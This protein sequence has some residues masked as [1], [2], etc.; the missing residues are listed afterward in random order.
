M[1]ELALFAGAGGGI[2]GG[3]LLGWRTVCAVELDAYCRRVLLARQR[4][5]FLPRFPIWDNVETFDGKPW[6]GKVDVV[7]GGFP[8]QDLSRA[9][10]HDSGGKFVADGLDGKRSGLWRK[11]ADIICDVQ[12]SYA[13]VENVTALLD[14][15]IG[16]VL[17]DLAALGY[18]AR[19]GVLSA[20]ATGAPHH[21][22]RVF[23]VA[24]SKRIGRKEEVFFPVKLVSGS[25]PQTP[26]GEFSRTGFVFGAGP[27][28]VG[29]QIESAV[30]GLDD[31]VAGGMDR[32]AAAGNAQVPAV[33]AL[34]WRLL[35]GPEGDCG[36][37]R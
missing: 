28:R 31:R 37:P 10:T 7:S 27:W 36:G 11:M 9:K 34:A 25:L 13:L 17:R 4:D 26:K 15:G 1:N 6:R 18:D 29:R 35:G 21:R 24:H 5:G 8:C 33:A 2:L 30:L 23:L 3:K 22:E 19:W 20:S 32:L 14:H 16:I 12:P